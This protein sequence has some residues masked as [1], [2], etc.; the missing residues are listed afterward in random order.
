MELTSHWI[1]LQGFTHTRRGHLLSLSLHGLGVKYIN[2]TLQSFN[3]SFINTARAKR[4]KITNAFDSRKCEISYF[5]LSFVW[6]VQGET[7]AKTPPGARFKLVLS[8][9]KSVSC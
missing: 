8:A 6:S 2:K 5:T 4:I 9:K 3:M 7:R 1:Y